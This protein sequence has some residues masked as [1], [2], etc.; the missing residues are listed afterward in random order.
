MARHIDQYV[1]Q[2]ESTSEEQ[3]TVSV[4]HT[5]SRGVVGLAVF[6]S[7]AEL[8]KQGIDLETTEKVKVRVRDGFVLIDSK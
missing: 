4:T 3:R 5:E 2:T 6:L 8:E 7:A 1:D